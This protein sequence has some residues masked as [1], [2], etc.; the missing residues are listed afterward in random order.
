M[1]QTTDIDL[2]FVDGA[3]RQIGR[4]REAVIPLLQAIQKHYS[5]L[6]GQAMEHLCR[7]TEITPAEVEGVAG[8]GCRDSTCDLAIAERTDRA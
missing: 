2:A 3:V 4:R 8:P 5:Y 1:T 6:P 7:I